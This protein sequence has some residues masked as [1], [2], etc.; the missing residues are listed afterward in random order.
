MKFDFEHVWETLTESR[1]TLFL[2]M[3]VVLSVGLLLPLAWLNI[4]HDER[5]FSY[6][7]IAL[8]IVINSAFA[9]WPEGWTRHRLFPYAWVTSIVFLISLLVFLTGRV[10][11][12][13]FLLYFI[14]PFLALSIGS[15][16]RTGIYI[17]VLEAIA[18]LLATQPSGGEEITLT[19]YRLG[20]MLVTIYFLIRFKQW[21]ERLYKEI[22]ILQESSL[23]SDTHRSLEEI[24]HFVFQHFP[25]GGRSITAFFLLPNEQGLFSVHAAVGPHAEVNVPPIG[26]DEGIVGRAISR[27]QQLYVPDVR[28][29]PHYRALLPTTQSELVVPLILHDETIAVLNLE[30][31]RLDGFSSGHRRMMAILSPQIALTVRNN[32]LLEETNKRLEDNQRILE[33]TLDAAHHLVSTTEELA[34][35][36]T[37][38]NAAVEEVAASAQQVAQGADRQASLS[39]ATAQIL[40]ALVSTAQEISRNA[41]T[42]GELL[43]KTDR[44]SQS[45]EEAFGELLERAGAIRKISH[46]AR[47]LSDQINLVSL[48]A[49]IEAARAGEHGKGFAVVADEVRNLANMSKD[50]AIEIT[51]QV[52]S[53]LEAVNH[54]APLSRKLRESVAES[55][56]RAAAIVQATVSQEEGSSEATSALEWVSEEARQHAVVAQEVGAIVEQVAASLNNIAESAEMM[57]ELAANLR[58][59]GKTDEG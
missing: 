57:A 38:V 33:R 23:A 56:N 51:T 12:I 37:Q 9:I 47:R 26:N 40:Q 49:A 48:N 53:I 25:D 35:S 59:A 8:A 39:K 6:G 22:S 7:I 16:L 21:V 20:G 46:L 34:A 15:A 10:H 52:E 11:S 36:T 58:K 4:N 41:A 54:L 31:D 28:E 55:T 44:L 32:Q 3:A 24:I 30:C 43:T 13:Y 19:L 42:T 45:T 1:R 14:P 5:L 27:G 18:Y 29:D 2:R 50:S 17:I